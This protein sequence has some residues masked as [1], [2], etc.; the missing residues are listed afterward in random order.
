MSTPT[1]DGHAIVGAW[2]SVTVTEN[3]HVE[4]LSALSLAVQVTTDVPSANNVPDG[5]VHVAEPPEQLSSTTGDAYFTTTEFWPGGAEVEI[6]P[7]QVMRGAVVSFT[8]TLN[9]QLDPASAVHVTRV[10]PTAKNEFEGGAHATLP[11]E[12]TVVGTG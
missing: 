11:H 6:L 1:G 4:V 8:V 12:P 2:L 5:G 7:A 3:E 9:E 10:T